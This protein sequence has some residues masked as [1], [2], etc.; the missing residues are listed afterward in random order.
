MCVCVCVCVC[1]CWVKQVNAG[2]HTQFR[3]L[4]EDFRRRTFRSEVTMTTLFGGVEG[5]RGANHRY[6]DAETKQIT[7]SLSC[8]PAHHHLR[9]LLL[10]ALCCA[11]VQETSR[12]LK[13]A[14]INRSGRISSGGTLAGCLFHTASPHVRVLARFL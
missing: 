7:W 8:N 10:T 14:L 9:P 1:V 11:A 5:G 3:E 6:R 12:L 13:A 4:L 2:T